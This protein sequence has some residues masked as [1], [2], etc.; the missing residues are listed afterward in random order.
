MCSGDPIS[1]VAL[2]RDGFLASFYLAR[3]WGGVIDLLSGSER[4]AGAT[5]RHLDS[6]RSPDSSS[7]S[8]ET[9]KRKFSFD[10][11]RRGPR[12]SLLRAPLF[13]HKVS[14]VEGEREG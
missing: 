8:D 12:G 14:G 6:A 4:T 2:S 9:R 1:E 3:E 11:W 7:F 10:E 13:L 5:L